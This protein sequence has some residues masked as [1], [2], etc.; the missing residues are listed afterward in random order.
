M[1][2]LVSVVYILNWFNTKP[3][4]DISCKKNCMFQWNCFNVLR[5]IKPSL[6][7]VT[8]T[9]L[10]WQL[11]IFRIF[12]NIWNKPNIFAKI[13]FSWLLKLCVCVY[14]EGNS[15]H[16]GYSGYTTMRLVAFCVRNIWQWKFYVIHLNHTTHLINSL[17]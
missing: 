7:L 16:N 2:Q 12:P 17:S 15:I 9:I 1:K 6:Y 4:Y 13:V 11:I 8:P 14:V 5:L 10:Y 3:N